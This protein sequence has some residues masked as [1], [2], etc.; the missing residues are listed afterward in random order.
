MTEHVPAGV[1]PLPLGVPEFHGQTSCFV[2]CYEYPED[3]EELIFEHD[4][5]VTL[6]NG[7]DEN[8][9]EKPKLFS[10]L[11]H[12]TNGEKEGKGKRKCYCCDVPDFYEY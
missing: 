11:K 5:D 4:K 8:G 2:T 12:D 6:I 1:D 10:E 7:I 9:R 3:I